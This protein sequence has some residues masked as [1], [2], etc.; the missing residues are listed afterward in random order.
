MSIRETEEWDA[1]VDLAV[2]MLH[3]EDRQRPF[4]MNW[5]EKS[6]I[7]RVKDDLVLTLLDAQS[8]AHAALDRYY[9]S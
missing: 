3:D 7:K 5:T 1:A 9:R 6:F 2:E 4:I 8:V